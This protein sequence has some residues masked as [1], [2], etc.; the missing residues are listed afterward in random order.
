MDKGVKKTLFI[1]GAIVL[2]AIVGAYI[3]VQFRIA[4]VATNISTPDEAINDLNNPNKLYIELD[5][6][7]IQSDIEAAQ[8]EENGVVTNTGETDAVMLDGGAIY[9][10]DANT[11]IYSNDSGDSYDANTDTL[12][13]SDGT[14]SNIDSNSVLFGTLQDGQFI[15][16]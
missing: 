9:I 7:A 14:T 4:K 8:I 10:G 11:G 1:G 6:S 13:L 15:N 3:W 12:T 2:S 5:N 16:D